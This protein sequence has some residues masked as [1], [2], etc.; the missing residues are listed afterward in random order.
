MVVARSKVWVYGL[1]LAGIAG[2]I[3]AEGMDGCLLRVMRVVY[4]EAFATG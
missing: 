4:V 1:T 3:S 2:S